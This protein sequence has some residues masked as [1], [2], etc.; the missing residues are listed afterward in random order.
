LMFVLPMLFVLSS[1]GAKKERKR[2]HGF[3]KWSIVKETVQTINEKENLM[4]FLFETVKWQNNM[5]MGV[6]KPGS[7]VQQSHTC[8]KRFSY[9]QTSTSCLGEV[10]PTYLSNVHAKAHKHIKKL[11]ALSS[12]KARTNFL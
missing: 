6:Y 7:R 11:I 9:E 12:K 10:R 1:Q 2:E 4:G 8:P 3:I 5:P